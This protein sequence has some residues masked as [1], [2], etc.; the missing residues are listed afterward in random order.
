MVHA[1]VGAVAA[2]CAS[3]LAYRFVPNVLAAWVAGLAVAVWHPLVVFVGFYSSEVCYTAAL[4]GGTLLLVRLGETGKGAWAA[5]VTL[6][7]AFAV[8][9]QILLT[10]AAFGA[11]LVLAR[12]RNKPLLPARAVAVLALPLALV[13]VG[14]AFRYQR[15][16][17]EPR[18]IAAYEP[19]QR[20]FGETEVPQIEAR[21]TA[22]NGE[23]W[24]WWF[25]AAVKPPPS[26]ETTESF[27]GFVADRAILEGRRRLEGVPWTTRVAR[28]FRNVTFLV[29]KN[30]P[31][32][33]SEARAGF[34]GY[35]QRRF[36]RAVYVVL[37]LALIGLV[38]LRRHALA[39]VLVG[40]HLATIVLVAFLYLGEAGYRV[41]Y[42]PFFL[43]LATAGVFRLHAPIVRLFELLSPRFG[44]L[45]P[46]PSERDAR[47]ASSRPSAALVARSRP[48]HSDS[49]ECQAARS[50]S[51][52][53]A[54]AHR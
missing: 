3:A 11:V 53:T 9:P 20:L 22:P 46:R 42:D 24:T 37:A 40:I 35:L 13:L 23:P 54:R 38:D 8:R 39:G 19:M 52:K 51:G 47:R 33:E 25:R 27:E 10:L 14:S 2:P 36:A 48:H 17:G 41:P 7:I 12:A 50:P 29:A 34:R 28:R 16:M 5:G 6:A 4:L 15:L 49:V 31:W 1:A 26:P 21:W 45:R 30:L 44:A 18:L 43:V 32:P